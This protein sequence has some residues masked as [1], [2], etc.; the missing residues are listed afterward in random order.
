MALKNED[1]EV[2]VMTINN[3]IE[4]VDG[5]RRQKE[6]A[7]AVAAKKAV[8]RNK[9]RHIAITNAVLGTTVIIG[10]LIMAVSCGRMLALNIDAA[11]NASLMLVFGIIAATTI[12]GVMHPTIEYFKSER[13]SRHG[14]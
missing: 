6:I 10:C 13:G 2:C 4:V 14:V 9:E 12:V 11:F 3:Q 5:L 7:K 8:C 1:R